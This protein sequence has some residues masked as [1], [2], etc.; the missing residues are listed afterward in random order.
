MIKLDNV[1]VEKSG[2]K[3]LRGVD[4]H[5]MKGESVVLTGA[6]GAGK[7]SIMRVIIGAL[8]VSTG[9]VYVNDIELNSDNLHKVRNLI[10]YI[11]QEPVMGAEFVRDALLLPFSFERNIDN[12]PSNSRIS[13][14]L[15]SVN[16][17]DGILS[18]RS[19]DISGG[20]RQRISIVRALLLDKHII[21]ADELTS[22]LDPESKQKVI[23]LL[24]NGEYTIVSVSHDEHWIKNCDRVV[25]IKNGL[26]DGGQL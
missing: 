13:E 7:S 25:T 9:S 11:G 17:S 2:A 21:F 22:A 12:V 23:S 6:S 26:V 3:I 1:I 18:K 16:L 8:P 19:V 14:L 20:E 24:M 5:I 4:L 15:S 10:A